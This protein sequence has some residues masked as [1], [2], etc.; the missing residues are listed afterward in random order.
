MGDTANV[1][2]L[3]AILFS[4]P[5]VDEIVAFL[6]ARGVESG[7]CRIV[8]QDKVLIQVDVNQ[9]HRRKKNGGEG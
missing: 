6:T 9:R 7:E 4:H 8:L 3:G 5:A 1:T 2:S